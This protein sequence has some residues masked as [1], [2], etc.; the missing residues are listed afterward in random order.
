MSL[1]LGQPGGGWSHGWGGPGAVIAVSTDPLFMPTCLPRGCTPDL[2]LAPASADESVPES[3]QKC[4]LTIPEQPFK[5]RLCGL[6]RSFGERS[7][8]RPAATC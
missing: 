5:R 7:V 3:V 8:F 4:N 1:W 2:L 6:L